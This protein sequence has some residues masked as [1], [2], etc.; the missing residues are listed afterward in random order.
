MVVSEDL[1]DT[2]A[3][4]DLDT[5]DGILSGAIVLDGLE[6]MEDSED[7]EV[8]VDLDTILSG[9]V[10]SDMI[11]SGAADLVDSVED[12]D[13]IL[14]GVAD[15]VDSVEDLDMVDLEDGAD[16]TLITLDTGIHTDLFIM[17][18]L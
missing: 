11:L 15:S 3:L 2:V 8:L 13:M 10:H 12:L 9:L 6:I 14:S 1:A 16:G 18:E 7:T 17:V 4:E 5:V